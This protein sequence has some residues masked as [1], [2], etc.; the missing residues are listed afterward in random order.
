MLYYSK[1]CKTQLQQFQQTVLDLETIRLAA[2]RS[3]KFVKDCKFGL[4]DPDINR[5]VIE[6]L[7]RVVE[8]KLEDSLAKVEGLIIK[9]LMDIK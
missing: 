9:N 3:Q 7:I 1:F 4:T 8:V 6:R 5:A 2:R